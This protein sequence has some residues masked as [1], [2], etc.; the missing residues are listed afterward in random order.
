MLSYD[1]KQVENDPWY[2]RLLS[3]SKVAKRSRLFRERRRNGI[4]VTQYLARPSDVALLRQLGHLGD[5]T[6]PAAVAVAIASAFDEF[7]RLLAVESV[8][9]RQ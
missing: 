1:K 7:S 2:R 4:V 5:D 8:S 3:R 6:R 9:S